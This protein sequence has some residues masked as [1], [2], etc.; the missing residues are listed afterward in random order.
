MTTKIE[1]NVT[2]A[3]RYYAAGIEVEGKGR[4]PKNSGGCKKLEMS[5]KTDFLPKPPERE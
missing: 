2:I 4:K 5:I 3:A 1:D